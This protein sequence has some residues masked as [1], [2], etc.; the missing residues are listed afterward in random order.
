MGKLIPGFLFSLIMLCAPLSAKAQPAETVEVLEQ[1]A[2][3]EAVAQVSSSIVRIETVGGRDV[4]QSQLTATAASTGVVISTDGYIITSSYHF[5][6]EPTSIIVQLADGRRFPATQVSQDYVLQVTLLKIE[7]SDLLVP[8]AVDESKLQVGQWAL[9]IGKTYS[10]EL[11]NVTVGIVSAL[12]RVWGKAIVQTD[13]KISPVNY[14][15]P[16]IDIQGKVIGILVPLAPD[17]SSVQ[18]GTDW[19]DSGI[20]FAVSF[21]KIQQQLELMKTGQQLKKGL[22]GIIIAGGQALGIPAKIENIR[23]GS[24]AEKAGIKEGDLITSVNDQ[25]IE[26]KTDL[27]FALGPRYA[28]DVLKITFQRESESQTVE[29]TLVD[30]LLPYEAGFIGMLA[31]RKSLQ[32]T[33]PGVRIRFVYPESP[34]EQAGL[35]A[36]NRVLQYEGEPVES[37]AHLEELVGFSMVNEEVKLLVLKN[38]GEQE[39]TIKLASSPQV[40]LPSDLEPALIPALDPNELPDDLPERGRITRKLEELKHRYWAY[41]PEDYNPDY[42]YSLLIWIHPGGK[43]QEAAMLKALRAECDKRGIIILAPWRMKRRDGAMRNLNSLSSCLKSSAKNTSLIH[44]EQRSSVRETVPGLRL[45]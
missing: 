37:P 1:Q 8:P 43:P 33:E 28:G 24:P 2:F 34:A 3:Q 36:G 15:G 7:T 39:I 17:D 32:S 22:L 12:N 40:G 35:K 19:Y 10:S 29:A 11:P 14:G 26:T 44:G 4:V 6:S 42:P 31:E 21:Q 16:L 20:G 13:A 41:I 23:F 27:E 9:G 18:A 38:E 45:N 5:I 25:P 30:E